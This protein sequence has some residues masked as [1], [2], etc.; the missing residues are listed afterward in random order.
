MVVVDEELGIEIT[1]TVPRVW[2]IARAT[3]EQHPRPLV[4]S[5]APHPEPPPELRR[6][7]GKPGDP[8]IAK[9]PYSA[10]YSMEAYKYSSD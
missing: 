5:K 10:G 8:G 2:E 4:A 3:F 6:G 7:L 9:M 1:R